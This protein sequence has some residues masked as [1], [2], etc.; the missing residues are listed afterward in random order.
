MTPSILNATKWTVDD[1]HRMIE[2][3]I[4]SDRQ[5]ELLNGVIVDMSPEGIDH[6][7]LSDEA[8]QYLR[9]LLG[10]RAKVREAKPIT[11]T[12]RS[13]P[14]PDL[15]ICQN[16]RYSSHHPYPE[17]IF[18]VIEYSDSSLKKDLEVKSTIYAVA[19]I[20]EYWVVNLKT[21]ELIVFRDPQPEG[22]T[23]QMTYTSETISPLA[24]PD[25]AI[26][27]NRLLNG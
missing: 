16:I 26:A 19:D 7:D 25:V 9:G 1:Y 15:C 27:V 23:T 2:A 22:Y 20:P 13:E 6:A 5:V 12:N 8:A 11:L 17:D 4:L 21:R 18:W 3:G 24:F 10:N 14:E